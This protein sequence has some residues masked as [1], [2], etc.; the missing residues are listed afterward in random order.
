MTPVTTTRRGPQRVDLRRRQGAGRG[1]AQLP[2]LFDAAPVGATGG[3]AARVDAG[4][5]VAE[6][7]LAA[8]HG[9]T[10]DRL[11]VAR[12]ERLVSHADAPCLLCGG[13][14]EPRYGAHAASIG[15]RCRDCGTTLG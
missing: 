4:D 2:T 6:P 12:W 7:A 13:T 1:A 10:L 5:R 11:V 14:M 8:G 3:A 9:G 15:G